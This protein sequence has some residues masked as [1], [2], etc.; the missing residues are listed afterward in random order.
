MGNSNVIEMV[1]QNN[2]ED[3]FFVDSLCVGNISTN[4]NLAWYSVAN[5]NDS[6]LKIK[7]NTGSS[8]NDVSWKTLKL[9]SSPP[10]QPPNVCLRAYGN[11]IANHKI[12]TNLI[13]K[14]NNLEE[15][16]EFYFAMTKAPP[17]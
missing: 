12:K 11:H 7:L 15:V 1:T 10:L 17:Y 2:S 8:A 5:V 13:C 6:K 9:K 16:L 3:E 4:D 14:I